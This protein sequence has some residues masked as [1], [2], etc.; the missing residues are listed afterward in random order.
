MSE[1]VSL[2]RP[3]AAH[4]ICAAIYHGCVLDF[5]HVYAAEEKGPDQRKDASSAG[6]RASLQQG[7]ETDS[8]STVTCSCAIGMILF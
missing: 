5:V 3:P 7:E 2:L 8:S 4:A 1:R 6:T